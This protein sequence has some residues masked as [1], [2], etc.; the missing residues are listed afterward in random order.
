MFRPG[1]GVTPRLIISLVEE[2]QDTSDTRASIQAS[3]PPAAV[4]TQAV[5]QL[6]GRRSLRGWGV[7]RMLL[8]RIGNALTGSEYPL[9][10]GDDGSTGGPSDRAVVHDLADIDF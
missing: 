4:E 10:F 7:D 5:A 9:P 3:A 2:L 6:R 8:V 1:T